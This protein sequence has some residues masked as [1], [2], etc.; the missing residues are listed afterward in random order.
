[1]LL[2][3]MMK[4]ILLLVTLL[5]SSC[6]NKHGISTKYYNECKEYYDLQGFYHKECPKSDII[7]YKELGEKTDEIMEPYFDKKP[8]EKPKGNVW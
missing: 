7:S 6:M 4:I 5:F 3:N 8:K 2:K 1:M